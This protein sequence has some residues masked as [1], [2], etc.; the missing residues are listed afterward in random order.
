LWNTKL[1]LRIGKLIPKAYPF[2]ETLL[3]LWPVEVHCF[4]AGN[5]LNQNNSKGINISFFCD[6]TALSILW[7]QI[8][9][10]E[11]ILFNTAIA[12]RRKRQKAPYEIYPNVPITLVSTPVSPSGCH[13]ARPKSPT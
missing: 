6:L 3:A 10:A 11:N 1:K 4:S 13:L 9:A 5:K 8:P 12:C 7:S 2:R